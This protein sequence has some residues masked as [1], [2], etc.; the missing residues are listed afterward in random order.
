MPTPRCNGSVCVERRTGFALGS[1]PF[2]PFVP[3]PRRRSLARRR[4]GFDQVAARSVYQPDQDKERRAHIQETLAQNEDNLRLIRVAALEPPIAL[5]GAAFGATLSV[6]EI[7]C[8][9]S[10][11][12]AWDALLA[13]RSPLALVLEDDARIPSN[14]ADLVR[15]MIAVLPMQ[16]DL[17]H[18]YDRDEYL[19]RPLGAVGTEH[20]LVRYS[21]VPGGCVAYLIS[22]SGARKLRRRELRLWPLDTDFRRPWHSISIARHSARADRS[23]QRL[24]LGNSQER[25]TISQT[26]RHRVLKSSTLISGRALEHAQAR[27]W[28][29]AVLSCDQ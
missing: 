16:W 8:Y 4:Q 21:R 18:L 15:E 29:V 19:A 10:H 24:D 14:L 2:D 27:N 5:P 3:A 26:S 13:S 22:R 9:A 20:E 11:M 1:T 6:G 25:T 28:L 7:G 23:R 12:K 17:V